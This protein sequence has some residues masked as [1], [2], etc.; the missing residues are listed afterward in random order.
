MV[1]VAAMRQRNSLR[2]WAVWAL[3]LALLCA[4]LG[5]TLFHSHG[6]G[7]A[8]DC[9]VC[10]FGHHLPLEPTPAVVT[11]ARPLAGL[12]ALLPQSPQ[13]FS[14]C[15]LVSRSSRAPPQALSF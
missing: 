2:L 13:H 9:A 3:C 6:L 7:A 10:H 11:A 5:S 1:P 4:G 12:W 8:G 14:D 15:W